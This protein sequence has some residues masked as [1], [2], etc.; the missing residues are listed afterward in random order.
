MQ[1]VLVLT[2]PTAAGKSALIERLVSE[3]P[4]EIVSCD[5]SQVYRGLDIGTAKPLPAVRA[6]IPHHLIDIRAADG[7]YSAG[8]FVA[9]V[10]TVL[11]QILAR[12]HLPV[13]VGGTMLYLRALVRGLAELPRA[14]AELRAEIDA[15][16]KAEGWPALHAAL[17]VV[18]PQAALRIHPNDPQRIQRA[19]EVYRTT[20]TPISAL[21][22]QTTPTLPY[23]FE[24]I[25]IAPPARPVLHRQI[26]T[27]FAG[28]LHAGLVAEVADLQARGNLTARH[29]SIRAVGY[30]QIWAHLAGEFDLDTATAKAVAATRQLAKR[31]LTWL[32]SDPDIV[33]LDPGEPATVAVIRDRMAH[34][35]D[36]GLR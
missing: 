31:Q 11:P 22:R 20:G 33:W 12:G 7:S 36:N 34:L 10:E 25:A 5:S 24:R 6:A 14:T 23:V 9:D 27:R 35:L 2:G 1:T 17:Q 13:I 32:R 4:L 8:E 18:D 3:F 29:S 30:R 28:M 16:A 19:L 15:H 26:E 21:Q